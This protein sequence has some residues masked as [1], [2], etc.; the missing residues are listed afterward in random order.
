MMMS[1]MMMVMVVMSVA[2]LGVV[3]GAVMLV[4][5]LA[6]CFE[7]EGSVRNA[8]LGK[9]LADGV[10]DVVGITVCN[11]VQGGI[12]VVA[13]HAPNVNVVNILYAFDV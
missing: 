8:V 5:M 2:A 9:L 7:L 1:V 13:I 3:D 12:V 11:Y 10:L 6:R 4:A